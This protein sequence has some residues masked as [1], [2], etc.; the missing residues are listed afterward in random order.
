MVLLSRNVP[1]KKLSIIKN[2]VNSTFLGILV[3]LVQKIWDAVTESFLAGLQGVFIEPYMSFNTP[4]INA[5]VLS[6][7]W[8]GF[9]LLKQQQTIFK[10]SLQP[11]GPDRVDATAR[12]PSLEVDDATQFLR[13]VIPE[14]TSHLNFN[15]LLTGCSTNGQSGSTYGSGEDLYCWCLLRFRRLVRK[16]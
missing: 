10:A 9:V 5:Q 4:V 2:A 8:N 7:Q 15:R 13:Y 1:K 11:L 12:D 16:I 3:Q 6:H 14:S